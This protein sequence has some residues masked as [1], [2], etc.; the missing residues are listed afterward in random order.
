MSVETHFHI[1]GYV[2][3]TTHSNTSQFWLRSN[4][5]GQ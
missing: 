4:R 1:C 5:I 3:K 2:H